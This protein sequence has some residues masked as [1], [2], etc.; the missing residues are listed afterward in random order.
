VTDGETRRGSGFPEGSL[1]SETHLPVLAR[2]PAARWLAIAASVV[3]MARGQEPPPAPVPP[4]SPP[5]VVLTPMPAAD[6][7]P[8]VAALAPV[9]GDAAGAFRA[10]PD[11]QVVRISGPAGVD[12]QLLGPEAERIESPP[13]D[14][15]HTAA[16]N[17]GTGY[18][19]RVANIPDRP[20]R[21]FYMVVE[22]VGHLH[23]PA[24]ID[25]LK[26]P[27]RI[28][29]ETADVDDVL[30]RGRMVTHVVYL[31]DPDQAIPLHLPAGEIPVVDL[32]PAEDATAVAKALGRI[33]AIVRLGNRLPSAEEVA[34]GY[35]IV[36]LPAVGCPFTVADGGK[37]GL[38]CG[39]EPCAPPP[40]PGRPWLPKDEFLCDGGDRGIS[41]NHAARGTLTGVEP[42]D[43]GIQFRDDRR[44]RFL[45]TNV[46]CVYAPRFA[47]VRQAIGVNEAQ[48]VTI[49]QG[50]DQVQRQAVE[51]RKQSPVRLVKNQSAESRQVRE[52]A[53]GLSMRQ[54]VE[55]HTE[56]RILSSSD[57]VTHLAGH[58]KDV[59][60]EIQAMRT[61]PEL[62][63]LRAAAQGIK[64]GEAAVVTGIVEGAGE[65]V[66]AWK[67]QELAA[68]E[69]PPNK[70]GLAV[71]KQVSAAEANPGDTLTYTISYRNMGNVP[72]TSVSVID[73]LL[74]R[75]EYVPGSARGPA[76]A[77]FTARPNA[78]GSMELRWDVGTVE[79]GH[80]GAVAFEVKVR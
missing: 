17:V 16:L 37:C 47:A 57:V 5:P 62:F 72:I 24:N 59:G 15:A 7:A 41:A 52:R 31:E 45:P 44:A 22:L 49:L 27:I 74:P 29:L 2:I 64:L 43:A 60:P 32:T 46:V 35:G 76:G 11:A 26:H 4:T 51:E 28:Q 6:T 19:Y 67:P 40:G 66:R 55:A 50:N 39:L 3:G 79:P 56:L 20:G 61:G 80:T 75:L 9:S 38:P 65:A 68:V 48:V 33:M 18:R 8:G 23:R 54:G 73:S 69:E 30:D 12:V 58:V 53:S 63:R 25:P 1:M 42:R 10:N 14:G 71:V 70:P 21:E 36:D 77:V 78:T 34:G 13:G